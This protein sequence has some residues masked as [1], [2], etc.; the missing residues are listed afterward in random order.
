MH[1]QQRQIQQLKMILTP[2]MIQ[3]F[4]L[5]Q[6]SYPDLLSE[7]LNQAKENVLIEVV[8]E[9]ALFDQYVQKKESEDF[10]LD[11][12]SS[13]E[14]FLLKQLEVLYLSDKENFLIQE[15]ISHLDHRGY[16]Q[17]DE[18][19]FMQSHQISS[20]EF[21]HVLHVLQSLEPEGVGARN[22]QEC[23]LLQLE[24]QD[25]ESDFLKKNIS[26][27]IKN[28]LQDIANKNN[29]AIAKALSLEEKAVTTLV[30]YIQHQFN[31]NP[32]SK[33]CVK[34]QFLI[35]S[36]EIT[37]DQD[38]QLK[39]I[40]LENKKG[41][42]FNLSQRYLQLLKD[43]G[44]DE[45]TRLFLEEKHQQAKEWLDILQQRHQM[46][47]ALI[48]FL[49]KR[50]YAFFR[51]GIS[52][53]EPLLQKEISTSLGLSSSSVSR[54]LSNKS[55]KTP[56]G[57]FLLKQLCPRRYFGHT[58]QRF[59]VLLSDVFSKFPHLSDEKISQYLKRE[60][61]PIARRTV[62]KYRQLLNLNKSQNDSKK[63]G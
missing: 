46:M 49:I 29:Q 60:G 61:I 42:Q 9:D 17:L 41:V 6:L 25:F 40:N 27:L 33:F 7:V 57:I 19:T 31:P 51:Y 23:L 56:H 1:L 50:Q 14:S 35:P 48:Q 32:G 38:H 34:P 63:I 4:K 62:N 37:M 24:A 22:V 45:N 10:L 26:L 3:R 58:S 2:K 18:D 44:T 53:L 11:Q 20:S 30:S 12:F 5:L 21:Q 55:V 36:F 43:P 16:L 8:K 54:I 28:H 13:L 52:Y 47:D 39:I 15:L 59:K